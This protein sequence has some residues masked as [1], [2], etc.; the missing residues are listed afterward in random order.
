LL[1]TSVEHFEGACLDTGAQRT[2]IGEAQARAFSHFS[3]NSRQL[4]LSKVSK[5]YRF[6]RGRHKAIGTMDID[7]PLGSTFIMRLTV[8]VVD[9]N[10]PFLLGLDVMDKYRLYVNTVSN[11]LVC[12]NEGVDLPVVRK[13]GHVYYDWDMATFYS[14]SELQRIHKNFF[15]VRPDSLYALMRSSKDKDAVPAA[16]KKLQDFTDAC[17]ICQRHAVAPRRFRVG[18]PNEDIL[19]N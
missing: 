9:L 8:E 18:M 7:V 6:G 15:H 4:K 14:F 17:D 10:V 3:A 1:S 11:H 2:V 13:Y 12:V 5:I 19:L 16:L